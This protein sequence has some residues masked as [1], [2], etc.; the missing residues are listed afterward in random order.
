MPEP[1]KEPQEYCVVHGQ[2]LS[3]CLLP[4]WCRKVMK[5]WG[6]YPD[7]EDE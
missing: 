6:L 3:L 5:S 7:Q 4:H 1:G 2:L